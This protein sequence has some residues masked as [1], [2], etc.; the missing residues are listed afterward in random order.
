M[1]I[2]R[3]FH[4]LVIGGAL[5]SGSTMAET[6]KPVSNKVPD[7]FSSMEG[8]LEPQELTP[9]FCNNPGACVVGTNGK[10]KVKEGFECCW[11]TSCDGL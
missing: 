4:V 7:L 2:E 6:A 10:K 8:G 1:Q 3:L 11:G 5:L 9:I